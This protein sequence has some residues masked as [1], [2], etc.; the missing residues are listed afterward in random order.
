MWIATGPPALVV[1]QMSSASRRTSAA[2]APEISSTVFE[3]VIG[4]VPL[5]HLEDRHDLDGLAVDQLDLERAFQ[6]GVDRHLL[7]DLVAADEARPCLPCA[8]QTQK[9]PIL[10]RCSSVKPLDLVR[11]TALEMSFGL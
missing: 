3:V 8:S 6:R 2:G 4:E 1:F 10:A 11:R 7:A 9:S 5:V